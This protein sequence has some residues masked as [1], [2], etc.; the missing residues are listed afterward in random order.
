[1][2]ALSS[3]VNSPEIVMSIVIF[4]HYNTLRQI[5]LDNK[6]TRW[7]LAKQKLLWE[8]DDNLNHNHGKRIYQDSHTKNKR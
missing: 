8:K 5:L 3:H 2:G 7:L 6:Y 4:R 1:L